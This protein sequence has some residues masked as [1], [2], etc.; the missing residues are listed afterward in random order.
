M[1]RALP[2]LVLGAGA[3]AGLLLAPWLSVAPN[4]LMPGAPLSG[5][6]VLGW[7]MP[8][9]LALLAASVLP[10]LPRPLA[11]L[12]TL[13]ALSALAAGTGL[14]AAALG[15]DAG[16][17]TRIMLGGGAWLALA[18]LILLLAAQATALS[19]ASRFLVLC[20]ALLAAGVIA[21]SGLLDALSIAVEY[22]A[23]QDA[24]H[25]ELLWHLVLSGAALALA[26]LFAVPA[27]VAGFASSRIGAVVETLLGA[28]QVIPAI[29]LFGLLI[30]LLS[31]L[32]AMAPA[33]RALGLGAIGTTPALIGVSLYLALPLARAVRI[34]LDQADPAAVEA[35][36]AMGMAP[37]RVALAVRVPLAWP[38]LAAGLRVATV[39]A[40]GFV[41]LGG[42]IGAGGL[43]ALV[44]AGM[45]QLATDL[46]LLGALPI[47][48]LAL[49]ADA[50]LGWAEAALT[51]AR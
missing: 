29:A 15:R 9:A 45:A 24:V 41:T 13:A 31:L 1:P 18:C 20:A 50:V 5:W 51:V 27:G 21:G 22:R 14:A 28:I 32:L 40:I 8:A 30:P 34:G 3:C 42:L 17:A 6:Q 23:R 25:A 33:L 38:I 39:Q 49:A 4:R 26:L 16:A 44:F 46:I 11:P 36:R 47:V 43:G 48:A 10:R 2:A 7:G 19:R 37:L 12:L 35:A